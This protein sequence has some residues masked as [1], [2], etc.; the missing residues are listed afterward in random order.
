MCLILKSL[1]LSGCPLP[2]RTRTTV[3]WSLP[4]GCLCHRIIIN[5]KYQQCGQGN[6]SE[7]YPEHSLT[8]NLCRLVFE[9]RKRC[10][11]ERSWHWA[12]GRSRSWWKRPPAQHC[13][14]RRAAAQP[15]ERWWG[16]FSPV[17]A[18]YFQWPCTHH[19]KKH[20]LKITPYQ[21]RF[22]NCDTLLSCVT[23]L[24][25]KFL[26]MKLT[27]NA[28]ALERHFYCSLMV[29]SCPFFTIHFNSSFKFSLWRGGFFKLLLCVNDP[30]SGLGHAFWRW[31]THLQGKGTVP[32]GPSSGARFCWAEL[33]QSGA[34][35][36]PEWFS[37]IEL[38]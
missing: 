34:H 36:S 9:A 21:T 7:C 6:V 17:L 18:C 11:L 37:K 30:F 12:A 10:S 24:K 22:A 32:C 26:Y 19:E 29:P 38:P 3:E 33:S 28:W 2:F 14:L 8:T 23:F 13:G 15:G 4:F 5:Q 20:F 31:L 25:C 27:S 16:P 35:Y 1:L